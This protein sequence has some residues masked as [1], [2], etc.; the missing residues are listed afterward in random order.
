MKDGGGFFCTEMG[1]DVCVGHPHS[2]N[3][4]RPHDHDGDGAQDHSFCCKCHNKGGGT[5][6]SGPVDVNWPDPFDPNVDVPPLDLTNPPLV[7][8]PGWNIPFTPITVPQWVFDGF[9]QRKE[10]FKQ[11]VPADIFRNK[12]HR[13]QGTL[14]ILDIQCPNFFGLN[15]SSWRYTY[16]FNQIAQQAWVPLF[17]RICSVVL[18]FIFFGAIIH[19][20]RQY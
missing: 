10:R 4:N 8:L 18:L 3:V 7:Q 17:R 13:G 1:I 15:M 6:P 16:D 20:L 12:I 11:F 2:T 5:P 14:P 9:S 19:T